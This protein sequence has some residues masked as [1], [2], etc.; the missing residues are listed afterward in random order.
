MAHKTI[1]IP[2][3]PSKPLLAALFENLCGG[4]TFLY[5]PFDPFLILGTC[6]TFLY[7]PYTFRIRPPYLLL[8]PWPEVIRSYMFRATPLAILINCVA[9]L[10][11]PIRAENILI[12]FLLIILE[13]L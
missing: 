7:V 13:V 2:T 8:R 9:E 6:Y 1:T 10:Y 3:G 12:T 4:Y 11:V 5:V